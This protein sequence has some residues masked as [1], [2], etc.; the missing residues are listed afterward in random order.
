MTSRSYQHFAAVAEEGSFGR[1]AARLGVAQPALSQ[2]IQRLERRLGVTLLD[3]TGRGVSLTPSGEAFLPEALVAIAASERAAKLAA[4]AASP[5][6][7]L[8]LGVITPALWSALGDAVRI[9]DRL[10]IRLQLA[11]GTTPELAAALANGDLDLSFVAPRLEAPPRMTKT[12]VSEDRVVAAVPSVAAQ[13]ETPRVLEYCAERLILPPRSYGPDFYDDA[14]A[15]FAS[16]GLR[17]KVVQESPRMLTT[18]ALVAAGV[19]ASVVVGPMARKVSVEGV[20]YRAFPE[21]STP[22]KW[23]VALAH[24]PLAAHSLAAE[25][26]TQWRRG[27]ASAAL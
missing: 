15:L 23:M 22:P 2:S 4:A 8:R 7:R 11:E 3:R 10:N 17:P 6:R 16:F 27:Q 13:W 12:P 1:A 14:L 20:A 18:L 26:M 25:F 5:D 19:G 24:M 9:A 21:G